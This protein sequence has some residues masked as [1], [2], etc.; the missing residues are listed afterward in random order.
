[1][2][3]PFN[4]I[5]EDFTKHFTDWIQVLWLEIYELT[6]GW[7]K[8]ENYDKNDCGLNMKVFY[9]VLQKYHH[10]IHL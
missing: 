5:V 10:I 6:N 1:M 8:E 3:L 4:S 9:T 2:R 7:Q